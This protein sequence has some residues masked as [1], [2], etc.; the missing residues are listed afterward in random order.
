ML[1]KFLQGAVAFLLAVLV[2]VG[3]TTRCDHAPTTT[4]P[5]PIVYQYVTAPT[6]AAPTAAVPQGQAPV[7]YSYPGTPGATALVAPSGVVPPLPPLAT[8]GIAYVQA[9][10]EE[11]APGKKEFFTVL[12][13]NWG[14]VLTAFLVF[15]EVILRLTPSETDNSILNIIKRLVDALV[16]NKQKT[17]TNFQ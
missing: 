8:P 1:S 4:A 2:A 13:E 14:V 12:K 7:V 6:A 15:L 5:V 16:P 11:P 10:P 9:T 17:G 3:C